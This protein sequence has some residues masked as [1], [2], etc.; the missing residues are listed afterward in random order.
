[1]QIGVYT[2]TSTY[3]ADTVTNK[4]KKRQWQYPSV[5]YANPL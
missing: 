4:E 3:K 2:N 1:M 5:S